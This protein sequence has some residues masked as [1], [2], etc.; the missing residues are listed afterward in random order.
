MAVIMRNLLH[1]TR[2]EKRTG[3]ANIFFPVLAMMRG[4]RSGHP[5]AKHQRR[6]PTVL[7]CAVMAVVFVLP[8]AVSAEKQAKTKVGRLKTAAFQKDI[9][10]GV[11]SLEEKQWLSSHRTLRVGFFE[12]YMP[13]SGKDPNGKVTGIVRDIVPEILARLRISGLK[14][15]FSG[16]S[17][18][19]AMIADIAAGRIDAAFPVGGGSSS[20]KESGLYRSVPVTSTSTELVYKGAYTEKT[21]S[22]FAINKDN[23]MQ[24]NFIV[25]IF[26]DSKVTLLPSI[27][28][29]L[30]AVLSGEVTCTTLNGLRAN[31]ILKN[32]RYRELS[33]HQLGRNDDRF[34]GVG[35]GN[36]G[37]LKL[38][39]RG[40]NALGIDYAQN[41]SHHYMYALSSYRLQ[42][43]LLDH[44]G[45]FGSLLSAVAAIIIILLAR[46]IKRT[47]L[48]M[49]E[50]DIR[51]V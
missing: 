43:V 40:L 44:L 51:H 16:Y 39:D 12:N 33:L 10:S 15:V 21:M 45:L 18:Y 13:Y 46:D 7:R 36:E 3:M 2:P 19:D 25:K 48:Q 50:K 6:C 47:R 28:A 27:D 23:R 1:E 24:Y 29:C 22:H 9:A 5:A 20:P 4:V 11:L 38:L 42:D 49:A 17:S 35:I 30:D 37:L 26:P 41:K 34:F 31:Y 14:V 8:L 32:R